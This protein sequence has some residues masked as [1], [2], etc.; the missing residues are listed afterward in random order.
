MTL[1]T[2]LAWLFLLPLPIACVAWTVT[3]EEIFKEWREYCKARCKC[4]N[5]CLLVRKFFYLFTC[6]YCFSHWVTF[7]MLG[8]TGFK[9]LL[10]DWR[11]YPLAAFALVLI[12]NVYM[13]GYQTLR[14][15]LRR[16]QNLADA[17][18]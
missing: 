13:T 8:L 17:A 7:G 6:E 4:S 5:T 3:K 15:N 14:A 16:V 2:Q 12:A 9:F 10:N 11:G 18:K 1:S